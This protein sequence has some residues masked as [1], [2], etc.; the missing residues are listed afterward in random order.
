MTWHAVSTCVNFI[1]LPAH[2]FKF[3]WDVFSL[4]SGILNYYPIS[5]ETSTCKIAPHFP[6]LSDTPSKNRLFLHVNGCALRNPSVLPLN[7]FSVSRP[8]RNS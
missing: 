6:M 5:K 4:R 1:K 3:V 8:L 7:Y 2:F